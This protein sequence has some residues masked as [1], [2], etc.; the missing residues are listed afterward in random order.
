MVRPFLHDMA[1]GIRLEDQ[2]A[3]WSTFDLETFSAGKR[4]WDCRQKAVENA[5]KILYRFYE[6]IADYRPGD[7][8]KSSGVNS[9]RGHLVLAGVIL[10][11]SNACNGQQSPSPGKPD[12]VAVEIKTLTKAHTRVVWCQDIGDGSD[13]FAVGS[14]LQLMGYDSDDGRGERAI[15]SKPSS[16][17]R[18]MLTPRGNRIIFSDRNEKKV[19]IVNWDGS[20]LK[21]L[22]SGY[23]LGVWGNPDTGTEWVY[24]GTKVTNANSTAYHTICRYQIDQPETSE[25]VW[26]KTL[27]DS[28]NLQLSR[29]GTR[30]CGVFPWPDCGIAELPNIAWK[31]YG[32]GCWPS[33]APDN[34]YRFWIFDG[35]HRNITLFDGEPEA[36]RQIRIN[37]APGIDGHEVYHPRWSNRAQFMTITGPYTVGDSANKIRAGGQDVEIYMGK[38][39]SNFKTIEQW[40]KVTH[41]K[42]A[43]FYPD[44]WIEPEVSAPQADQPARAASPRPG[45]LKSQI[46]WP[47]NTKGLVFLWE[48]RSKNNEVRDAS[49]T[50]ICNAEPR[51]LARY[52]KYF[53]M[54]LSGG[55]FIAESGA[56]ALLT[57]CKKSNQVGVEAVLTPKAET[58]SS[59]AS[60]ALDERAVKKDS[61]RHSSKAR[62]PSDGSFH[63]ISFASGTNAWNF[64]LQEANDQLIFRLRTTQ[65]DKIGKAPSI[66][67]CRLRAGAPHHMIVSYS[68]GRLECFL[69]GKVVLSTDSVQ[70]NLSNWTQQPLIFGDAREGGHDWSGALEGIALYNRSIGEEEAMRKYAAYSKRLK[71]RAPAERLVVDARLKEASGIPTPESI[72]PYRRALVVNRYD[73]VNVIEGQCSGDQVLVAHWAILD[74]RTLDTAE[75]RIDALYRVILEPFDDRPELE[76]ERLIM[77]SDAFL[78]PLYYDV[79]S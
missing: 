54:D 2:P 58:S 48:N 40:V 5:V 51:D 71:T 7:C 69:N 24:V 43:D 41:N 18:P 63:I 28:D 53:E 39:D 47:G 26:D 67:L 16:Y 60:F 55:A 73:V 8:E 19:Y 56:D 10:L 33:L 45:K 49:V 38:F 78:L 12:P 34:S 72:T 1:E 11:I 42:N 6:R 46:D 79:G 77:D 27:L 14:N 35:A 68:P 62:R 74:G 29:D 25:L 36:R 20:G 22:V 21:T 3:S 23:A 64:I 31:K 4:L 13:T 59:A 15:L 9:F 57:E 37:N 52:G 17:A 65:T 70:G 66:E 76:G 30:S 75:R 50:R 44:I 32:N 61:S